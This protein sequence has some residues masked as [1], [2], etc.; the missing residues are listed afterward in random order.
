MG[1]GPELRLVHCNLEGWNL[2]HSPK[3]CQSKWITS[4]LHLLSSIL[5]TLPHCPFAPLP[6]LLLFAFCTTGTANAEVL[7]IQDDATLH[8]VQFVGTNVGWAVGDRGVIWHTINGG[9]TWEIVPSPVECPLKSICFLTDRVGW[10]AGGGTTPHT[11]LNFGVLLFTNNAGQSWQVLAKEN[12]PP[13]EY[14]KFFGLERGVAVGA[15]SQEHPTGVLT[16]QNGGKTW[17]RVLGETHTGWRTAE[18][19]EPEVGVVAGLRGQVKLVGGGRL[20]ASQSGTNG[21]QNVRAV[22]MNSNY[23]G[24]LAGDGGLVM[25]TDNGGVSWHPPKGKFPAAAKNTIDFRAV[26][27]RGTHVWLAGNPGSVVW[28]SADSG[29]TW[30]KQFTRQTVPIS[31]LEFTSET[32]GWAVGTMGMM[33]WTG[34]GGETWRTIRGGDRRAAILAISA[35][36]AQIPFALLTKLSGDEGYR[37]AV[38]LPARRDLGLDAA[39]FANLDLQLTEAVAVAGGSSAESSW[40]LPLTIPG[41]EKNTKRLLADWN[42]RTENQFSNVFSDDLVKQICTWRPEIIVLNSAAEEDALSKLIAD[43]VMQAIGRA[44]DPTLNLAL[45]EHAGLGTWRVRKIYQGLPPGSAGDANVD[46][47]EY[48]PRRKTSLQTATSLAG[49][50]IEPVRHAS[51]T[52]EAYRL[53]YEG[54]NPA[55]SGIAHRDFFAGLAV[56]PN[57]SARRAL[58]PV[59]PEKDA[60]RRAVIERQRNFH[61]YVEHVLP[62]PRHAMQVIGQ[63]RQITAG[64][65]DREA[66]LELA[67]LAEAYRGQSQWGLVESTLVELVERYPNEPAAQEAMRWLFQLWTAAEPAWQ[68]V[69]KESVTR[70]TLQ[71]DP[72]G[73]Q[74]RINNALAKA[75]QSGGVQQADYQQPATG[76]DPVQF[77][78]TAGAMQINKD[79]DWRTGTVANWQQQGVQMATLIRQK[80]PALFMEPNVQFPLAALMRQKGVYRL[81]DSYYRRYQRLGDDDRWKTNAKGEL[82]LV[83]PLGEPPK[84]IVQCLPTKNRPKLDG[85]LSETCWQAAKILA[86]QD[87][88]TDGLYK[89][90]GGKSEDAFVMLCYDREFLYIAASVPRVEHVPTDAAQLGGREHD[91]DLSPFDRLSLAIDVDRDYA[92]WYVL[93]MDQR[94]WTRDKCWQDS[95]WN[96][97][98]YVAAESDEKRWRIEAAIP[99]N[100][101]VPE[102]PKP[103]MTWA[104]GVVRTMP[105]VGTQG[106]PEAGGSKPRPESFGLLRFE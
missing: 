95:G 26:A 10:I 75:A 56:A 46:L 19:L 60:Q 69:R 40:R 59:D 12:V 4:I 6:L 55:N 81:S 52:R 37:S 43:A 57:S 1:Q 84:P 3:H 20:L 64:M 62:K 50:R 100:E 17:E 2:N 97:K 18:F 58:L 68:R 103:G 13:L 88:K 38:Y 25:Q 53:I 77:V 106:W 98:W 28:H 21:L 85:V 45:Q 79:K 83:N 76:P 66:A 80:S 48:L 41:L 33:L 51:A 22:T 32:T 72:A 78:T 63:L 99:L 67:K 31:A 71:T 93:E 96:P 104:V 105:A 101:L 30:T 27:A 36:P 70:G 42:A 9:Q 11:R 16:T 29:Q 87:P 5:S 90:A 34:D 61:A 35:R 23:G 14:V 86:L 54:T 49:A 89:T 7:P 44:A 94:G 15:A 74:E 47:H 92:T 8:D 39:D 24:W 65:T 73:I 82:W 91:A 102:T